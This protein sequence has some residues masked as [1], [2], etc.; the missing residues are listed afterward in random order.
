[1][2]IHFAQT[3]HGEQSHSDQRHAN[4]NQL[5]D[6]SAGEWPRRVANTQSLNTKNSAEATTTSVIVKTICPIV[7]SRV[8]TSRYSAASSP[9]Y[10]SSMIASARRFLKS[11]RAALTI[12][13]IDSVNIIL[14][15]FVYPK[16]GI[17]E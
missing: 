6:Q 3:I 16:I 10:E 15:L 2:R 9:A 5:A 17:A 13:I 14:C 8:L 11:A 12:E 1:M 4:D 7:A